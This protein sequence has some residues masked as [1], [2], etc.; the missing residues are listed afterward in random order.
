LINKT[1]RKRARKFDC[2]VAASALNHGARLAT[3][4]LRDFDVFASFG[5]AIE[6]VPF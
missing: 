5:L 4:N 3:T 6:P 2:M 1:G